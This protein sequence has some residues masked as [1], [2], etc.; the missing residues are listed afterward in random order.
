MI[1][2]KILQLYEICILKAVSLPNKKGQMK[3][4]YPLYF[5]EK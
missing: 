2:P 4:I 5:L 3:L 1:M